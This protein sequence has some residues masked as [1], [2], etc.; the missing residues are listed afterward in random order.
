MFVDWFLDELFA[1]M[2][3]RGIALTGEGGFLSEMITAVLERGM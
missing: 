3:G 2:T 1:A